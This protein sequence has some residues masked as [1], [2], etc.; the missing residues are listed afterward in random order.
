[1]AFYQE[2]EELQQGQID[3]NAPP[4]TGGEGGSI[5]AGQGASPTPSTPQEPRG[6]SSPSNFV[7]LSQYLEA[8]K[9]QSQKLGSQVA[10]QIAG[11]ITGAQEKIGNIGQQFQG[12]VG[13]GTIS[14]LDSAGQEA[15]NIAQQTATG[16]KEQVQN[17]GNKDR[18]GEVANA[19]YRGPNQL[20]ETE[21]YEPAYTQIQDAQRYADLSKSESGNQQLLR[22]IYKTPSYSGGESRLDAY[23]LKGDEN[24][25]KL[26]ESRQNAENLT[27]EFEAADAGAA[28]YAKDIAA[29]TEAARQQA[30]QALEQTR[31]QRSSQIENELNAISADWRS[32]YDKYLN[33]LKNSNGGQNL[34][35]TPEEAQRLGVTQGQ[36][37]FNLLNPAAG[38]TPEQYLSLQ[39]FDAN[40][41]ISQDQ[42]AQLAALDELAGTYG[43]TQEN[44]Y[45]QADLAGSLNKAAAFSAEKFGLSATQAKTLFDQASKLANMVSEAHK[46]DKITE[47]Q[48]KSVTTYVKDLVERVGGNWWNP[49]KWFEEVTRAVTT[50]LNIEVVLG[51]VE[52]SG[53]TSGTVADYLAG[54]KTGTYTDEGGTKSL[55]FGAAL[56]PSYLVDSRADDRIDQL[57]AQIKQ[58]TSQ[59]WINQIENYLRQAGY[60]N[61]VK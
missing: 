52:T 29:K 7:G 28:Q 43:G 54:N 30:R 23:L 51:N 37:I 12:A 61:Q 14:N 36:K 4:T 27:G 32:E 50:I 3:P 31:A 15:T 35:L 21:F 53:K 10:G 58:E 40:K 49:F 60:Y 19:Q 33:L 22:D 13:Q 20:I 8:N 11:S 46:S 55:D 24:R 57:D 5:I 56:Q 59:N 45:T 47:Q 26:A 25:K 44:K 38:N 2:D 39:Q 1:M 16:T 41:V 9:P 48:S 17:Q 42:Q 34:K 18:F 6:P